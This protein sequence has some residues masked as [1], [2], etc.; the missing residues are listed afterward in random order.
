MFEPWVGVNTRRAKEMIKD[1]IETADA[2]GKNKY[3]KWYV[4]HISPFLKK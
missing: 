4:N 2:C 3:F 1:K